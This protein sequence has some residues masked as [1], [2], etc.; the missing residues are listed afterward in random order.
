MTERTSQREYI[1]GLGK[2]FLTPLYDVAHHVFGLR[3]I[4][5]EMITLADLRAGHRILDVGCA[6]GNLLRSAG[7]RYPE[8]ELVGLDPDP[9]ALANAGRK[10][11]RA[12]LDVR[13]DRGFAQELPYP[14]DSFDRVFSS[15]MLHHLDSESKNA[16]LTE[17][18]RI[19]R[20]EGRLILA[21]AVVDE[22][23]KGAGHG[24]MRKH[25][26]DNIADAV[27]H[28]IAAAGFTVDPTHRMPLR[29]G[30][31]VGIEVARPAEG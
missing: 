7:K 9:R 1:P 30:G 2:H 14:D 15:L 27:N 19:L 13:L 4:H 10:F 31:T 3:R 21:D 25:L 5:Q 6:T 18:R 22:G 16:L 8:V 12:G 28:R 26:H 29:V 11:R 17:V 24:G 20:P 23:G